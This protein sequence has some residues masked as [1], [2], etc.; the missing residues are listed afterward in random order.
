MFYYMKLNINLEWLTA[1][2][3]IVCPL[4]ENSMAYGK[5]YLYLTPDDKAG[6]HYLS[7]PLKKAINSLF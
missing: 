7:E 4:Q 2:V 6:I 5:P 1:I 3:L